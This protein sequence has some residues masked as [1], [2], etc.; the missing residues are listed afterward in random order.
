M[1]A[2]SLL[3][4]V[5]VVVSLL[6]T[7]CSS[8]EGDC[9]YD[10]DC[11]GLCEICDTGEHK[12][13][14][15]PTC[16]NIKDGRCSRDA[17]CDPLHERCVNEVCVPRQ[18]GG[19]RDDGSDGDG[20]TP[21]DDPACQGDNLDCSAPISVVGQLGKTQGK[22]VD[23]DDWGE[24][25]DCDDGNT[26][27]NPGRDEIVYNCKDDDCRGDTPDDDLD[28]DG[29]GNN[30]RVC[31]PGTD[32]DD[33]DP[34]AHPTA[35]ERCDGKDNDCD[36]QTDE[37]DVCQQ[38]ADIDLDGADIPASCPD[39]AGSYH[40]RSYCMQFTDFDTDIAQ[41][42]C[43]VS[44]D[45][46]GIIC[47]GT[48]DSGMNLYV[49]CGGAIQLACT[50]KVS[51]S[52][53]WVIICSTNPQCSFVF[54][55]VP[56]SPDCTY[57]SDTAC[58][59][60]GQVCGVVGVAGLPETKCV[61]TS[62]GGRD[63]G[64]YCNPDVDINCINSICIDQG[65]QKFCGGICIVDAHCADFP[66]TVCAEATYDDGFGTTGPIHVCTPELTGNTICDRTED[67]STSRV[68][69]FR[70]TTDDVLTVCRSPQPGGQGPGE[71]C[72]NNDECE[73]NLCV[74]IDELCSGRSGTC[75][76]ICKSDADCT[77]GYGCGTIAIPDQGG[78]DH[79][80]HVCMRDTD[81]CGRD[82]DCPSNMSCQMF[83]SGT[84]DSLE[85]MC[86]SGGGD[87]T[88]NTGEWCGNDTQCF[89]LRC[90]DWPSYCM[91]LC[92]GDDDCPE[93]DSDP[94][95]T[96]FDTDDDCALGYRCYNG[97]CKRSYQC[98]TFPFVLGFD[99][100][101]QPIVDTAN[102]CMPDRKVCELDSE[103]RTGEA[104]KLYYNKTATQAQYQCEEGGPGS[105]LLGADCSSGA[106]GMG[107]CWT[108][109]CLIQGQ[110]GP[111]NEY[112]S[113]A[114][115]NDADC[116]DPAVYY[117]AGIQVY[118]RPGFISY[119]PACAKRSP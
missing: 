102:I 36:G 10:T 27:I 68:C 81:S 77:Q 42:G 84:G 65:T 50:A 111:G 8:A 58:T 16:E 46:D 64:Y 38:P 11:A 92:I 51:T 15:D 14:T 49:E 88:S 26:A 21:P 7:G 56:A 107:V 48:I 119:V 53:S 98:V 31:N 89:A 93:I 86:R 110:G 33:H 114:C 13:V 1:K 30:S 52:S 74:C 67:C 47:S 75:S 116:G 60:N 23:G 45:I 90:F 41:D 18:N 2:G 103:C 57:H 118:V 6:A 9:T 69:T 115:I 20:F 70:Q 3:L 94:F 39:M 83:V 79:Y 25:C 22:D 43:N 100:F 40:V 97:E 87:G 113:H 76:E 99:F 12:C 19:D 96:C 95:T 82:A 104:C 5:A 4:G 28:N 59:D 35:A 85:T 72:N 17:D 66:G 61:N 101:G 62:P 106:G 105:E 29:Y 44:V 55:P 80:I 109:L 117:C 63:P 37:D 32:C 73:T 54:D 108:G 71:P 91:G 78:T 24:C 34:T 112:C